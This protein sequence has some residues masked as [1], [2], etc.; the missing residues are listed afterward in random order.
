MNDSVSGTEGQEPPQDTT[1]R[2]VDFSGITLVLGV[3]TGRL[4]EILNQQAHA[5]GGSLLVLERALDRLEALLPLREQGPITPVR[6]R[7][8]QIPV[9]S[10][11]VDLLV[12]NGMLRE[13]PDGRMASFIGEVAR[14]MVPGGRLRV[15]DI[16]EPQGGEQTAAWAERNRIVRKLG[17]ALERPVAVA[18]NLSLAAR[19]LQ[20]LGFEQL[21]VALLPGY[22]LTDEWLEETVN[23][24]RAM[25]G[26]VVHPTVRGEIVEGDIPRLVSAYARGSQK[27]AERFVLQGTKAGS[28]ALDMT[29]SFTEDDLIGPED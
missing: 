3:G 19:V 24:A 15:S 17:E 4:L 7:P 20:E 13:V 23:A 25:A 27:A 14:A 2:G 8:R 16:I 9:L 29:A 12:V 5:S 10:E 22:A 1:W 18:A 11:T 6:G 21:S 28:L 26:R